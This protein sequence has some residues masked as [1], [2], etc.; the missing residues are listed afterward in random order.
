M[1]YPYISNNGYNS[2]N[3]PQLS[4]GINAADAVNLIADNQLTDC[5]NMWMSGERLITRPKTS[6]KYQSVQ[7]SI[8]AASIKTCDCFFDGIKKKAMFYFD[9]VPLGQKTKLWCRIISPG[10]NDMSIITVAEGITNDGEQ[11]YIILKG[12]QMSGNSGTFVVL[13]SSDTDLPRIFELK[14]TSEFAAIDINDVYKPMRYMNGKGNNYNTLP[15]NEQTHYS[16]ATLFEGQNILTGGFRAGFL[17]DGVS[18]GFILPF[19]VQRGRTLKVTV[20]F[21]QV[22]EGEEITATFDFNV[23][24]SADDSVR[25]SNSYGFENVTVGDKVYTSGSVYAKFEYGKNKLSFYAVGVTIDGQSHEGPYP[26]PFPYAGAVDNNITVL[27]YEELYGNDGLLMN[28]TI[29]ESFGG[30]NGLYKDGARVFVSG[31]PYYKNLIYW[32]DTNKPLYYSANNYI[33]IGD[34]DERITAL[35]KQDGFLAV[36]KEHS[37]YCVEKAAD[38]NVTDTSS[39]VD[40]T[41]DTLY[42]VRCVNDTIGCDLPNTV[43]LC[44]NRLVWATRSGEV[45]TLVTTTTT[46]KRNIYP[47]SRNIERFIKAD[48]MSVA[49]AID[50]NGYYMLFCRDYCY[51]LDYNRSS[52][53]YV[54]S[55]T[56]SSEKSERAFTW[57]KWQF[58]LKYNEQAIGGFY[59]GA[60]NGEDITLVS[61][62]IRGESIGRLYTVTFD[63]TKCDDCYC[64][65]QSKM[66][67]FGMQSRKKTV[68]K[69]TVRFGNEYQSQII[70]VWLTDS[71]ESE[72][73][74]IEIISASGQYG[75]RYGEIKR[76][77]IKS[78]ARANMFGFKF[79][80][81]SPFAIDFINIEYKA[82]GGIK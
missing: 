43:Q 38:L 76:L 13:K 35:A 59:C 58:E 1:I 25:S 47:V 5:V 24:S 60:V 39:I 37:V 3:I 20:D 72:G 65:L 62:G 33:Y 21:P 53:K 17:A 10:S 40:I 77:N 19:S 79:Y 75:N 49:F 54:A 28:M 31:N 63:L 22:L 48:D 52:Y 70:P 46:S 9:D 30:A 50:W 2:V 44:L 61:V 71:S 51:M 69:M 36:F 18:D 45:F 68:G 23:S 7:T 81:N 26:F 29:S 8:D 82:L 78:A 55:Y 67:D 6:L 56:K 32:S 27:G 74:P 57:W 12:Q 14:S 80:S 34:S 73:L 11:N 64:M 15:I 4:G 42:S 16:P 66:F 41:A